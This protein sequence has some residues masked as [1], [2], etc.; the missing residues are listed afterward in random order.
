[1]DLRGDRSPVAA[2]KLTKR[3][4]IDGFFATFVFR[5]NDQGAFPGLAVMAECNYGG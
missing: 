1:M 3:Q 5:R 4:R 2:P